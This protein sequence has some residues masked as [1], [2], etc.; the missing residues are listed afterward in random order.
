MTYLVRA[1]LLAIA[2]SPYLVGQSTLTFTRVMESGDLSTTGFAIGN[3]T[4][5]P[6]TVVLTLHGRDGRTLGSTT[7]NLPA[8]G[9][10]ARLAAELF[11]DVSEAGWV[12]ATSASSQ[13]SAFWLGGDFRDVGD[14]TESAMASR[15]LVVPFVTPDSELNLVNTSTGLLSVV[16]RLYGADG[17]EIASPA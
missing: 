10:V 4:N 3:P 13:L 1:L 6:A 5:S 15:D 7:I 8:N 9:Q 2:L 12:E 14:G 11:P 17:R 16:I